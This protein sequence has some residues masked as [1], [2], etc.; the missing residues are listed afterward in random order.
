MI[1]KSIVLDVLRMWKVTI[2]VRELPR[3]SFFEVC[4]LELRNFI[5]MTSIRCVGYLEISLH[6]LSR[7]AFGFLPGHL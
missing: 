6:S 3:V 4:R 1:T 2:R 7:P 5:L